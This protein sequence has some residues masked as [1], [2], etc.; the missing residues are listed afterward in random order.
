MHCCISDE[1]NTHRQTLL[2]ETS[3][4]AWLLQK[5]THAYSTGCLLEA[6]SMSVSL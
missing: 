4:A 6:H 5:H 1:G 2:L 3:L